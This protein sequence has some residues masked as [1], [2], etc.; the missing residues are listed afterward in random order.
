[1]MRNS[2]N[3]ACVRN[4]FAKAI[5]ITPITA[6]IKAA[7]EASLTL[8]LLKIVVNAAGHDI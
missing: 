8:A 5:R 6:A 2:A 1:M 4:V 3:T 7:R